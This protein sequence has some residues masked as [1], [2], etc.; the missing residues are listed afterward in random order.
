MIPILSTDRLN[1]RPFTR[2]DLSEFTAL[3]GDPR[4]MR[5][6]GLTL[7]PRQSAEKLTAYLES[8]A[9]HG[10]GRF[11]VSDAAGFIGYVGV[12]ADGGVDHPLGRHH[13]IGWRLLPQAWGKGYATEAAHV[14]LKDAFTRLRLSEVLAYTAPDNGPSQAV[15]TRLGLTRRP[16]MDFTIAD[17]IVGEWSGLVWSVRPGDQR[18]GAFQ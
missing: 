9:M 5:D 11:H 18:A 8:A 17:P 14:A 1:L 4:S 6:H 15:M 13:E 12:N 7:T 2:A 3:H 16:E 10:I